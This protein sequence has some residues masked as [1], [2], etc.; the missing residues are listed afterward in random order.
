MEKVPQEVLDQII[1]ALSNADGTGLAQ[2]ACVSRLFQRN[3]ESLTFKSI[4]V[5]SEDLESESDCFATIFDSNQR[6]LQILKRLEIRVILPDYDEEYYGRFEREQDFVR[7]SEVFSEAIRKTFKILHSWKPEDTGTEHQEKESSSCMPASDLS[8][9]LVAYS[10]SDAHHASP[11]NLY[12]R[13]RHLFA[14]HKFEYN[15]VFERRYRNSF[16]RIFDWDRIPVAHIITN[17][18]AHS[19]PARCGHRLIEGKSLTRLVYKMP[20]LSRISWRISDNEKRLDCARD[21][22]RRR[23]GM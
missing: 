7:N 20:S 17:F 13:R 23:H 21:R 6:R 14:L 2:Y 18:Q 3:I 4:S 12:E 8:L 19:W 22:Q 1:S 10:P 9:S 11:C 15:D 16:L 5:E